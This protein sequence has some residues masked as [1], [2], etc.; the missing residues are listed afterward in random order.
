MNYTLPTISNNADFVNKIS[1]EELNA[2]YEKIHESP[3]VPELF[4]QL[5]EKRS[6]SAA[7]QVREKGMPI[8]IIAGS[9][10]YD[11]LKMYLS[12]HCKVTEAPSYLDENTIFI[13]WFKIL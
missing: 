10:V 1:L 8:D 2:L 11:L 5:L 7:K 9:N 12:D 13:S 6:A 4:A 3:T